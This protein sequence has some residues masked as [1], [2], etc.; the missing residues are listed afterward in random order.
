MTAR[1]KKRLGKRAQEKTDD[2]IDRGLEK[3]HQRLAK[4]HYKRTSSNKYFKGLLIKNTIFTVIILIFTLG[5]LEFTPNILH[6]SPNVKRSFM[7][8][9][10][11]ISDNVRCELELKGSEA[12]MK[13]ESSRYELKDID[14]PLCSSKGEPINNTVMF[15]GCKFSPISNNRKIAVYL[16]NPRS[17][18]T[19]RESGKITKV[20]EIT[21][22]KM[23]FKMLF[24]LDEKLE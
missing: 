14:L 1:K 22:I 3:I 20:I 13:V 2:S 12:L 19:H 23:A 21:R 9:T 5:M 11:Y 10:C 4:D 7:I 24:G 17:S 16:L 6:D 8:N 18:L 15:T